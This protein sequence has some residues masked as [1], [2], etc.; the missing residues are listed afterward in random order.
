MCFLMREGVSRKVDTR[1]PLKGKN[2]L[3]R[4]DMYKKNWIDYGLENVFENYV[5]EA[6]IRSIL[7][8]SCNEFIT[9]SVSSLENSKL[10][11]FLESTQL[12]LFF[13]RFYSKSGTKGDN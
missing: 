9:R 12:L 10:C 5:C 8:N 13:K 11:I 2:I 4:V 6:I 3:D 1:N 7:D